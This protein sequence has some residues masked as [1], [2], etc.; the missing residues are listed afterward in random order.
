MSTLT[1]LNRGILLVVL[2]AAGLLSPNVDVRTRPGVV[3]PLQIECATPADGGQQEVCAAYER[4][5]LDS[6]VLV[7]VISRCRERPEGMYWW[8][9]SHATILNDHTLQTHNHYRILG[10]E[11][12]ELDAVILYTAEGK[13]IAW[14]VDAVKL[15]EVRRQLDPRQNTCVRQTCTLILDRPY[16]A[17][18]QSANLAYLEH[19]ALAD[20]IAGWPAVAEVSWH[21]RPG[22]T[23][24]QW[25]RV[26]GLST[27]GDVPVL[28]L[29]DAILEGA[30]GGGV[31]TT[32]AEGVL[33]LGN[34]WL[35]RTDGSGS[36]AALNPASQPT[37]N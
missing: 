32:T 30:S 24:V 22:T 18:A 36:V 12:C 2:A 3:K 28:E 34:I 6:T 7:H 29:A 23:Y 4:A 20:Q 5:I 15:A 19:N 21:G 37:A 31:W 35:T 17:P 25:V 14:I 27:R 26:S 11:R 33:Q 9:D 13:G 1:N 10:D 16:F 8:F